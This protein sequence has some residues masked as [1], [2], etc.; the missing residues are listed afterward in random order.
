MENRLQFTARTTG[1]IKGI[2]LILMYASHLFAFPDWLAEG[3][4]FVGI[5]FFGNTLAYFVGKFGGICVGIFMFLTGYGMYYSY[6]KGNAV[7]IGAK[8]VVKFLLKY[9]LL[10][11][12][13]FLPVQI[14]L[15]R[16]YFDP[17]WYREMPGTYTSIVGFAW[18]VRFYVPAMLTLPLLKKGIGKNPWIAIAFSVLPFQIIYLSMRLLSSHVTFNATAVITMEYFKYISVVLLGYCFAKFDLYT[19]LDAFLQK[20]CLNKNL[21]YIFGILV[22]FAARIKL[23]SDVY[24]HIPNTELVYAPLFIFFAARLVNNFSCKPILKA[25]EIIGRHSMNLWFLQSVFFFEASR[26]QW[27][28]YLP[29]LSFFVIIWNI[30]VLLPISKFYNFIYQKLHIL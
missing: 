20:H 21:F 27:I 9:W 17:R 12:T 10:L 24:T 19:R 14:V 30:V 11:F 15:G 2:A 22:V 3:N 7:A 16:T 26:L 28:V 5:P 4:G 6:K 23:S 18:Y 25:L 1:Q 13:F 29:K 8:K